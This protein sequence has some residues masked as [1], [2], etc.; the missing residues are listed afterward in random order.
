MMRM[1]SMFFLVFNFY[2]DWSSGNMDGVVLEGVGQP[3]P[4]IT[5]TIIV[6]A[7][8]KGDGP[9]FIKWQSRERLKGGR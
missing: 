2:I 3:I 7:P 6:S 8:S 5:M 9:A 1:G 4:S